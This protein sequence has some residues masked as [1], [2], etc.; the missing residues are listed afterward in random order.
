MSSERIVFGKAAPVSVN[1]LLAVFLGADSILPVIF[2]GKTAARPA[3]VWDVQ[4][5][6]SLHDGLV[7][8]VNVRDV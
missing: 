3:K 1:H 4:F 6:K 2:V 8:S 7:V 5:F